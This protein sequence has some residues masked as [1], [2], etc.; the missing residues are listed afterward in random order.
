MLLSYV[1]RIKETDTSIIRT[2]QYGP[3]TK[4]GVVCRIYTRAASEQ[5]IAR[6]IAGNDYTY[7]RCR[8]YS[9]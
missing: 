6:K 3:Y 5:Y 2:P 8:F 7:A 4:K 9:S 1:S